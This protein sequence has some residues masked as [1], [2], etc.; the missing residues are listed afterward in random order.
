MNG[1]GAV[2]TGNQVNGVAGADNIVQA[3]KTTVTD[4]STIPSNEE[5]GQIQQAIAGV[6]S[7]QA[8]SMLSETSA[9]TQDAI[10]K[11]TL[12]AEDL[13]KEEQEEQRKREDED[14]F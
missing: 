7:M 14:N 4:N 5:L 13:K 8:V 10:T 11:P 12:M 6:I 3:K 1:V 2:G 9:M